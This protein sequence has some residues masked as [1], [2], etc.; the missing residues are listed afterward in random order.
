MIRAVPAH[1]VVG[2]GGKPGQVVNPDP[3]VAIPGPVDTN[4]E[5]DPDAWRIKWIY[6][7]LFYS[8]LDSGV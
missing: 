1:K 4:A 3:P 8:P 7:C 5:A 2:D 6:D